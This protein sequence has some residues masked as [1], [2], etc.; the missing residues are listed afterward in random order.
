MEILNLNR[1]AHPSLDYQSSRGRWTLLWK[2]FT[3]ADRA[4]IQHLHTNGHSRKSWLLMLVAGLAA[5]VRG[6]VAILTLHSGLLPPYVTGFGRARR[7]LAKWILGSFARVVCVNSEIR[8][9]VQ[10]LGIGGDHV[11]VIPAFL[12]V[13]Q[14]A[15]LGPADRALI[16]GFRPLL[17]AVAGGEHDPEQGRAVVLRAIQQLAPRT[18][19]LG[20]VL[21]GWQVGPRS[22]PLIEQL[23]LGGRV[24]CLGEVSHDRCLAFLRAGDVV[25]RSTFVDGDAITVR[26]A[27]ALGVAVVASDTDFRPAGV[28]LFR[29]GDESDL[30]AKLSQVLAV[31]PAGSSALATLQ[32]QPA[33][34]IWQLYSELAGLAGDATQTLR[35]SRRCA[36]EGRPR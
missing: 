29:K 11:T 10:H 17:V 8:R 23:G 33:R 9:A 5:R 15:E 3:A 18:P 13:A 35:P 24:V 21:L 25:V 32:D 12:G 31:T 22:R 4:S 34:D 7:T 27:L 14:P 26:E 1:R 28:T 36:T 6:T 30:A 2:L 20:A 16:Q 19:G